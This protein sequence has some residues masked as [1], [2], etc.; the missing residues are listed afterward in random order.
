LAAGFDKD[1]T[2]LQAWPA[3][4]FGF[5]EIGTV[6][7]QRQEGNP[8]PRLFRLPVDQAI[9]NRMG[10]NNGGAMEIAERL[11]SF[12]PGDR[13]VP[14]GVNVG[15]S[16]AVP[17]EQAADDYRRALA[18][19]WPHADY[20]V[21][22][23]SSPNTPNLRQLQERQRLETILRVSEE[24]AERDRRPVFVKIAPDLPWAQVDDVIAVVEAFNLG[25]IIACNTTLSRTG[26]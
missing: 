20:L 21:I 13:P 4:G 23:V 8:R 9:I 14:L 10:F 12:E 16:K 11:A 1:G 6:T 19:L 7:S 25:G 2:A 22:N 18:E 26:L 15:K 24:L 5:V 17:I 3:L